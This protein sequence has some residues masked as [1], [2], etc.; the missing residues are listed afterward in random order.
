MTTPY[1]KAERRYRSGIGQRAGEILSM[2]VPFG[3]LH[4]ARQAFRKNHERQAALVAIWDSFT[5]ADLLGTGELSQRHAVETFIRS[6][7]EAPH[8]MT[9]YSV[10][11]LQACVR[12]GW[13][14]RRND[15]FAIKRKRA[16][17]SSGMRVNE[18][19]YEV[20]EEYS[21]VVDLC[22]R[23]RTSL[24][25]KSPYPA[26]FIERCRAEPD[27]RR[28]LIAVYDL[29]HASRPKATT[30]KEDWMSGDSHAVRA[31]LFFL[32]VHVDAA[33]CKTPDEAPP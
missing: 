17:S 12:A 26:R 32:R 11:M 28:A 33:L 31:C 29:A 24:L 21:R 18:A 1:S 7:I 5:G 4:L 10:A 3:A 2:V 27:F 13:F 16:V 22:T 6:V 19:I 25:G 30:P 20:P 9:V 8:P 23:L 14:D 15:R